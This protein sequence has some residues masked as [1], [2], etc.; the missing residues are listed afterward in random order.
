MCGSK[1]RKKHS[2]GKPGIIQPIGGSDSKYLKHCIKKG[3]GKELSFI[4]QKTKN[5]GKANIKD[6]GSCAK[7]D[8]RLHRQ[9]IPQYTLAET[10]LQ[11]IL[12]FSKTVH[13][14][15]RT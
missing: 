15:E 14:L 12:F 11:Y 4:Q 9:C 13:F 7:C 5:V 3:K 10:R 6:T 8:R 2:P 1:L